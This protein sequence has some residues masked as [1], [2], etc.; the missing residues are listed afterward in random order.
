MTQKCQFVGVRQPDGFFSQ[1][2]VMVSVLA[3]QIK[4]D[5]CDDRLLQAAV[6]AGLRRHYC[7]AKRDWSVLVLEQGREFTTADWYSTVT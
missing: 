4:W 6:L 3:R 2:S 1:W 7:L 5:G